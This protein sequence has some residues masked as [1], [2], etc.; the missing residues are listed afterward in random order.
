MV[1]QLL[2][3][4]LES[5][6]NHCKRQFSLKTVLMIG[7]EMLN[8]VQQLHDR[9]YIHRDIKPDNF[10]IGSNDKSHPIYLIDLGL[11]QRFAIV[12]IITSLQIN[13]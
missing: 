11:A 4:S 8:R 2:G 3:P 7:L 9:G 13:D 10:V 12:E 1:L 6:F 5:L